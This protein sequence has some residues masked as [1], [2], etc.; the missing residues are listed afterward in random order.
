MRDEDNL[1]EAIG[2]SPQQAH[3]VLAAGLVLGAGYNLVSANAMKN[4][5][6]L[7]FT[8]AALVVFFVNDQVEW[9]LGILLGAGQAV[10]AWVAAR[11]AV[12]RG[13]GFVRWAVILITV[14]A[15]VALFAGL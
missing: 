3:H 4:F 6:V 8:A 12:T 2:Q 14:G 11:F 5:I 13:A 7:V 15:A 1:R 9:L 10:G